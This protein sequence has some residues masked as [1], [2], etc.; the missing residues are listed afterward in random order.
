[1]K[2]AAKK[3]KDRDLFDEYDFSHGVRGK[4]AM[5]CAQGTNIVVLMPGV[6]QVFPNSEA[7]ND[8]LRALISLARK[9]PKGLP[10]RN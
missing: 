10:L 5:R 3:Q 6:A 7:V 2:K 1:M 8:T 9:A 4:D